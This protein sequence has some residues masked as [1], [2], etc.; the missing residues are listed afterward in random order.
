MNALKTLIATLLLTTPLVQ[1]ETAD[2]APVA[3][4]D[5]SNQLVIIGAS[6]AE[7]WPI[8]QVGCLRVMNRGVGGQVSSEVQERFAQDAL[9][10]KPTAVLIWGFI[11]DF[12]NN[13]RDVEDETRETAIRN[14]EAMA[15]AAHAAGVIPVLATEVTMGAPDSVIDGIVL[16]INE[17]RGKRSYQRYISDNVMTVN[18]WIREYTAQR[19]F[20]LLDIERLMTDEDGNRKKGY[21]DSDL[22]HITQQAYRDLDAY[23]IPEL[24][25][26]LIQ[27]GG[28][29]PQ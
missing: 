4:P 15:E 17:L 24:K 3:I 25:Q 8:E 29:C 9:A 2:H 14:I 11:N 26:T 5:A 28:L 27:P 1:A 16:W 21:F 18:R 12:A 13:S 10:L 23:A 7:Q 19:G 22:S 6:Y 20:P